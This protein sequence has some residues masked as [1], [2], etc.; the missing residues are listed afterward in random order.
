MTVTEP[1]HMTAL[2]LAN[3]TRKARSQLRHQVHG[4]KDFASSCHEL[5]A[6][7]SEG[8]PACMRNM[9]VEEALG[10]VWLHGRK[11]RRFVNEVLD[12]VGCSEWRPVGELT[13]RQRTVLVNVLRSHSLDRVAA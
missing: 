11:P 10:W 5:A 9:R 1:Q 6:I 13:L 12:Q 7:L 3:A 8:A 2:A 4:T